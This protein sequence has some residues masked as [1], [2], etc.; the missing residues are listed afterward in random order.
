MANE[1]EIQKKVYEET[2]KFVSKDAP[3]TSKTLDKLIYSRGLIKETL[4]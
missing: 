2:S 4:R 1:P 3:I